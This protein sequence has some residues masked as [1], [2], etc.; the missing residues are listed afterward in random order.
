MEEE[1]VR[2][3]KEEYKAGVEEYFRKKKEE[4]REKE[5]EYKRRKAEER[6][7]REEGEQRSR[8]FTKK[9]YLSNLKREE[10]VLEKI[11]EMKEGYEEAWKAEPVQKVFG[12][13]RQCLRL[14]F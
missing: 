14:L 12:E 5:E 7:R 1:K 11:E 4:I 8:E 9:L 3:E 6:E 10:Q 13:K 2:R